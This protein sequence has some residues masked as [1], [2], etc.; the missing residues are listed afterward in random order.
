MPKPGKTDIKEPLG[1]KRPGKTEVAGPVAGSAVTRT[2]PSEDDEPVE[3]APKRPKT[4]VE[5]PEEKVDSR[6]RPTEVSPRVAPAPAQAAV[7]KGPRDEGGGPIVLYVLA[8]AA[9]LGLIGAIYW[10]TRPGDE[11]AAAEAIKRSKSTAS[12]AA[13]TKASSGTTST[14]TA[15]DTTTAPPTTPE[16]EATEQPDAGKPSGTS[17]GGSGTTH[18]TATGSQAMPP[19]F[20][21]GMPPWV[22]TAVPT[23]FPTTIPTAIP[24]TWQ[25]PTATST[26]TAKPTGSTGK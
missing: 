1:K 6:A 24:S 10:A 11:N 14:A 4:V 19:G 13:S 18:P 23:G 21:S 5:M 17:T 26:S 22:P 20:P 7:R 15:T 2:M 16:P 25:F 8:G 3:G 9:V 12:A